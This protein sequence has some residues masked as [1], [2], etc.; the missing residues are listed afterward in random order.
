MPH[1]EAGAGEKLLEPLSRCLTYRAS[2]FANTLAKFD[3]AGNTSALA[4][5]RLSHAS[6]SGSGQDADVSFRPCQAQRERVGEGVWRVVNLP[7]SRPGGWQVR[8]DVLVTD[9]EKLVLECDVE[10]EP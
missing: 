5:E 8:V 2:D 6:A 9:F 10:L 7:M 4:A 1:R 3:P